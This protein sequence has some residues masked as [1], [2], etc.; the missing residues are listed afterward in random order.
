MPDP[1]GRVRGGD[2]LVVFN[3][4]QGVSNLRATFTAAA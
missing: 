2:R 3:T 4:R 1:G